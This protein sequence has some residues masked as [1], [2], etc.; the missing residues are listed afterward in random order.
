MPPAFKVAIGLCVAGML[1]LLVQ[2]YRMFPPEAWRA[3]LT[4]TAREKRLISGW[5][6]LELSLWL[7][8]AAIA[9]WHQ[10]YFKR[11]AR[12]LL[13]EHQLRLES[14]VP[15][16]GRWLD[17]TLP[18]EDVRSRKTILQIRGV[19]MGS[20]ALDLFNVGW[21]LSGL[22]RFSPAQWVPVGADG[23][24]VTASDAVPRELPPHRPL[25]LVRWEHPDN[26]AW[27]QQ[28]FDAQP[29]VAALRRQGIELP[30]LDRTSGAWQGT[31]LLRYPRLRLALTRWLPLATLIGAVLQHLARHQF[32][33]APWPFLAWGTLIVAIG[34]PTGYW[35]SRDAPAQGLAR[36]DA[37]SVRAAQGLV[38][39][40]LGLV[41][42]WGLQAA[43]LVLAI[44]LGTPKSVD[45]V[46]D[47]RDN[48][49]EPAPGSVTTQSIAL[50]GASN[51]WAAQGNGAIQPIVVR[52]G[53]WGFWQQYDTEDLNERIGE[54]LDQQQ[55]ASRQQPAGSN[56]T[57]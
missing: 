12:L 10:T 49:L 23:T 51:F 19:A 13:D 17:W 11:R 18:L 6:L 42:A 2:L 7:L 52:E 4:A 46:L 44:G 38:A 57:P 34:L 37:W 35:L 21:G 56:R 8:A 16:I 41:L 5:H 29:L 33:F 39:T 28:R 45:F 26:K 40:L 53:V 15:W 27:L 1:V 54:Y 30:P 25:G 48:R 20:N 47:L 43:P 36:G 9:L 22:H 55:R 14:R 24:D 32:Y 3:A 50:Q 31:D